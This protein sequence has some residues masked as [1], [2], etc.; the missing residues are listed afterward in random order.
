MIDHFCL[1]LNFGFTVHSKVAMTALPLFIKTTRSA[2]AIALAAASLSLATPSVVS[3]R[4]VPDQSVTLEATDQISVELTTEIQLA[5]V[6]AE[7][8]LPVENLAL[9]M[10]QLHPYPS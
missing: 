7:T 6:P 10:P 4:V 3:A 5:E 8:E 9:P 2:W 1:L